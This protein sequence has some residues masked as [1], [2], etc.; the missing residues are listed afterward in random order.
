M[1]NEVLRNQGPFQT[2]EKYKPEGKSRFKNRKKSRFA[3]PKIILGFEIDLDFSRP[4]FSEI[5]VQI[6]RPS[7]AKI[8]N[9]STEFVEIIHFTWC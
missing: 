1:Y 7:D 6:K 2:L 9:G 5:R 4:W 3:E 8:A